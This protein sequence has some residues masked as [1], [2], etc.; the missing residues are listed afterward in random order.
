MRFFPL[1]DFQ[2]MV[3]ALFLGIAAL[4]FVYVAWSGYSEKR[5]KDLEE[6][7]GDI[8]FSSERHPMPPLLIFVYAGVAL[9]VIAYVLLIG[10]FGGAI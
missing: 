3:L 1:L 4:V 10:I 2:H 7:E 5:E 6:H 8:R 9:W